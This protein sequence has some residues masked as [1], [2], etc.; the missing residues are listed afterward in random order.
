MKKSRKIFYK[1]IIQ[2]VIISFIMTIIIIAI[3]FLLFWSYRKDIISYLV[4][5]YKI[6]NVVTEFIKDPIIFKKKIKKEK[7]T[8]AI[9]KKS[10]KIPTIVDAVKIAKPAV[11]SIVVSKEIPQYITTYEKVSALNEKG[12]I[13]PNLYI[14]KPIY[15]KN[16]TKKID[17]GSGS[18][19]IISSDGLI[20]TNRHVISGDKDVVL[21]VFLNDG[22]KFSAKV[23]DKD[24]VLDIALIKIKGSSFP[25]LKLS[26]S[27]KLNVGQTVIAI[28]NALGKFEN[29]VSV[30]VVSGLSRSI[31]AGDISGQTEFLDKVIQTDAAINK[32]NSGGPLLN[33]KGNVVG[34][35]VAIVEN[36]SSVGFSIPINSVK[37]VI[38][39]VIKTGKIVRPFVGVRYI[40]ITPEIQKKNDLL[41]DYGIWIKKGANENEP[42]IIPNSP[43]EKAGLK[44]DYILLKIDGI[45]VNKDYDFSRFIRN[46]KIGDFLT[47]EAYNGEMVKIFVV[48]LGKA[49]SSI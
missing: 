34:I 15:T 26:D 25:Y 14:D 44:E 17:L 22:K 24:P 5:E 43:A 42:G 6:E 9:V 27:S 39:S 18:G 46:K 23:I 8:P 16:G 40:I 13:I 38:S 1:N 32:G 36:S 21:D 37:S 31:Y 28:G 29:T 12:E 11:V 35:N 20:V 3:A 49:P 30:G 47:I 45:K 41:Y 10:K 33:I 7:T 2:S 19:F 48:V 4:K